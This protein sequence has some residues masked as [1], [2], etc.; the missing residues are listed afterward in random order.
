VEALA[1]IAEF[2]YNAVAM[3]ITKFVKDIST[4]VGKAFGRKAH[5]AKSD[6]GILKV[7][8][9]VAALDGDVTEDEYKAFDL[10]AKKCRGYTPKVAAEA[11]NEA[12]HAAGYL[13]LLSKRVKKDSELVS[14]FM[15][16]AHKALPDGFAYLSLE[17]VR[18]AIVTWIAMGL[19]DGDYSARERKCI[20]TLRKVFAEL[21]TMQLQQ[22]D[23]RWMALSADIHQIG[24]ID[25]AA[26]RA[27]LELVSKNFI[28]GVESLIRQYG[29]SADGAQ[30]LREL[31]KSGEVVSQV[32][33]RA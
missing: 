27:R 33:E 4:S 15:N 31:V 5:I 17:D 29:D 2:C 32:K 24:S 13:M 18:R 16:E 3:N 1:D 28:A 22:E 14:A 11:L 8:F 19:S 30:L 6:L 21:K 7:A 9:M 12:M 25:G 20:E 10:L 23:E 26:S